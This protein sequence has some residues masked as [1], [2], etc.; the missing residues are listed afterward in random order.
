LLFLKADAVESDAFAISAWRRG[1]FRVIDDETLR[2][3]WRYT[4]SIA[5]ASALGQLDGK[6]T[7][8]VLA[9]VARI[10]GR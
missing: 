1:I 4:V 3:P 10:M 7:A 6:K 2:S 9:D 5:P 8:D